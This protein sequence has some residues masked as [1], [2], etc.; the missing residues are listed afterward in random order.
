MYSVNSNRLRQIG[1]LLFWSLA[2]ISA[3]VVLLFL[4]AAVP[5]LVVIAKGGSGHIWFFGSIG[6]ALATSLA[7][8]ALA[9]AVI[10]KRRARGASG[11]GT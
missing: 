3:L 7:Y 4:W 9:V 2:A 1:W 8:L 6:F 5:T 11:V 10:I